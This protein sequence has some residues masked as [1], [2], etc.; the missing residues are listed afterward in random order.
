[1]DLSKAALARRIG[2]TRQAVVQWEGGKYAIDPQWI[3]PLA[4][5][6]GISAALLIPLPPSVSFDA[7]LTEE[8]RILLARFRRSSARRRAAAIEFLL[9]D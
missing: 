9:D 5:T 1:M 3:E 6:L 4:I 8:E 2:A 7:L